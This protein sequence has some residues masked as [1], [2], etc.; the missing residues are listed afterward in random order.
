MVVSVLGLV[1]SL[2]LDGFLL[3][4]QNVPISAT[5]ALPVP[6]GQANISLRAQIIGS[7]PGLPNPQ[8][9]TTTIPGGRIAEPPATEKYQSPT[10]VGSGER[11]FV[12]VAQRPGGSD[13]PIRRRHRLWRWPRFAGPGGPVTWVIFGPVIALSAGVVALLIFVRNRRRK[14]REAGL[15]GQQSPG[16]A[17]PTF[18]TDVISPSTPAQIYRPTD[19]GISNERLKT[20]SDLHA[21]GALTDTEFEAEK[22]RILG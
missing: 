14:R 2:L 10:T 11:Q 22:R 16:F 13:F 3:D 21:S 15:A 12:P 8:L 17:P 5:G 20:L 18:G 9:G 4:V 19:E 1:G 6:A 7:D